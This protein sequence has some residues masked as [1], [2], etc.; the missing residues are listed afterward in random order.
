MTFLEGCNQIF[1]NVGP[2]VASFRIFLNWNYRSAY[3][4]RTCLCSNA[5][6][7]RAWSRRGREK[8]WGI[9]ISVFVYFFFSFWCF[10]PKRDDFGFVDEAREAAATRIVS[11]SHPT[12]SRTDVSWCRRETVKQCKFPPRENEFNIGGNV[13][14]SRLINKKVLW[15]QFLRKTARLQC[16]DAWNYRRG[17]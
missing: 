9:C 11:V 14:T 3:L 12:S 4:N 15:G 10:F 6:I 1:F 13:Q 8:E 16:G 17:P 2:F 7:A 5:N